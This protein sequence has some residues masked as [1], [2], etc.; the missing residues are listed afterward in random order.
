M[1]RVLVILL[2]VAIVCNRG[3]RAGELSIAAASDLVFCLEDLHRAFAKVHPDITLR[4]T[5]GASGNI[6]AQINNGAP[7]DVYLSADMRYPRELIKAGLADEGSLTLYAIG[8]LV[9][10]TASDEIDI[11][12]GVRSLTRG[13]VHKVA[14][15]NPE[16]APYGRAARAAL[17]YFNLWDVLKGK[18][19]FGENI[20]QTAQFVETGNADAGV[21]AL[22]IVLAPNLKWKGRWI[23]VPEHAYPPLEQGAVITKAGTTNPASAA[24]I[25]FLASREAR[26]IFDRFGF[27]LPE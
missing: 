19:V 15:A 12:E 5:T 10:W 17:E 24:Y 16:H 4:A 3:A 13:S 21:V 7:F 9:V 18:L 2:S 20:A 1:H 27:R 11:S 22:S 6:F 14:I 25:E 26:R 23:A 8:H